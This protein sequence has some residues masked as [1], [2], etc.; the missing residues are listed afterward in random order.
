MANHVA[1]RMF[2]MVA[3]TV[4]LFA[5][6]LVSPGASG[7]QGTPQPQPIH[8]VASGDSLYSIAAEYG[9]TPD[10]LLAANNLRGSDQIRPGMRLV[11]PVLPG[12]KGRSHI[13]RRGE[14][15]SAI[16]ALYGVTIED[17]I[18]AN[19]LK[20]A[21]RIFSGQ[22]LYVP[23]TAQ[24]ARVST[25]SPVH[26]P[27]PVPT[28]PVTGPATPAV[29]LTPVPPAGCLAGCEAITI[30]DPARGITLTHPFTVAGFGASSDQT[31]VVRVLDSA[32][33][34][35][36]LGAAAVDGPIGEIGW[37]S[38]VIS[39]TMPAN[40]QPG[41][42]QV[43]SLSPDDGAIEHLSSVVV[44]LA[45]SGLDRTIEQVKEALEKKDYALL[46]STMSDPFALAFYRSEGLSLSSA[47]A[48]GALEQ[49][50][51]GPGDVRVDLSVN[52]RAVLG[53]NAVYSPEVTHVVYTTGWGSDQADDALLLFETDD[54][55]QTRWGG[56]LYIF[57][58]LRDY[59]A[60]GEQ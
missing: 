32:G 56:M 53:D 44:T 47:Q 2:R 23:V 52:G 29:T 59:P 16:A 12:Q 21:N 43:Y 1:T 19:G 40:T 41:R 57:D 45:G 58:A 55:G 4:L 14:T 49:T 27:E 22:K 60:P 38:G 6:L 20:D 7:A 51:L 48:L 42:V 50:Y 37:F 39:Y 17:L 9:V 46:A 24:P 18:L 33:Y 15:L 25:P 30:A 10:E 31:L 11:V 13:V 36:G 8:V 3:R 54:T 35:I 5:V 34:E 28:S 26:T